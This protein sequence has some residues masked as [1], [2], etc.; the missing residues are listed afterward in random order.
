MLLKNKIIPIALVAAL[1]GGSVGAIVSRKNTDTAAA[2]PSYSTT[3]SANLADARNASQVADDSRAADEVLTAK[4]ENI[5]DADSYRAGFLDGFQAARE[6]TSDLISQT[7][8]SRVVYRNAPA[9]RSYGRSNYSGSRQVYYDYN[10]QPRKRSFWQ[11]HR[12]KLTVAMGAGGGALLGGLIGGKKGA[13]IGA[14]AGGGGAAL[15]TYKLRKRNR[16]Y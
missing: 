7:A 15:Y 10:T 11:K 8:S 9:R 2:T 13:A 4:N 16:N 12:D 1:L 6:R 5:E 3:P 14:L